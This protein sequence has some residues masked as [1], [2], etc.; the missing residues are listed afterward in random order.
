MSDRPIRI[1][2][3]A[4]AIRAFLHTS[5]DVGE[6][7]A[8]V[9]DEQGSVG[10]PVLCLIEATK[11]VADD[12]RLNHL[13]EHEVATLLDVNAS[14]WRALAAVHED[15]DRLDAASAALATIDFRCFVLTDQPD[16]Y[17]GA[18]M[19]DRIVELPAGG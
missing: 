4:S 10:L 17:S 16:V 18:G 8:E 6:I 9:D 3:D 5:V 7:I 15:V 14:D 12:G 2:L 1:V 13:I 11:A 19:I